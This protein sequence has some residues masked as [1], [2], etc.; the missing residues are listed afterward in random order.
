[1]GEAKKIQRVAKENGQTIKF[2]QA[3]KMARAKLKDSPEHKRN[4]RWGAFGG[5]LGGIVGIGSLGA[6]LN[7]VASR[8]AAML[9]RMVG[10]T[11]SQIHNYATA[12]KAYKNNPTQENE[13][14]LNGAKLG[15]GI[16]L[17]I[18]A[19]SSYLS[20]NNIPANA[21]SEIKDNIQERLSSLSESTIS[22][23]EDPFLPQSET[24]T[25]DSL[26][27]P[28]AT[29]TAN[30]V[31]DS[32]DLIGP[33]PQEM[34]PFEPV[35]QVSDTPKIGD[36]LS[37]K[38][39][40]NGIIETITLGKDGVPQQDVVGLSGSIE[41]SERIQAFYVRRI[42]NMNQ[43]NNLINMIGR[44]EHF[45]DANQAV[46]AMKKQIELGFVKLPDGLTPEHAI[47]T[48]FMH[49][50][51]TGDMSAIRA[52]ACPNGEETVGMFKEL[53]LKYSTD[54]GFIGRP[55]DPDIKL[56]MRA[57]TIDVKTPCEPVIYENDEIVVEQQPL[58]KT[59]IT[60][61]TIP[62]IQT[63]DEIGV[64][65]CAEPDATV[66]YP[67]AYAGHD[68]YPTNNDEGYSLIFEDRKG[69]GL[70]AKEVY[71]PEGVTSYR[72]K[73]DNHITLG[74]ECDE[75][76]T[77]YQTQRQFNI[78]DGYI[79]PEA[80]GVNGYAQLWG[81]KVGEAFACEVDGKD[82]IKYI[83]QEGTVVT[84]DPDNNYHATV[85]H[86]YLGRGVPQDVQESTV[87]QA[88]DSIN[89]QRADEIQ[90]NGYQKP[91]TTSELTRIATK[92]GDVYARLSTIVGRK[93]R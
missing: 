36:I 57:G 15:L 34:V 59:N 41:T 65:Y 90:V 11:S 47:H 51:Y 29:L 89:E 43:Y 78:R 12:N 70:T 67:A 75:N 60:V 84:F 55:V 58:E 31:A 32:T 66:E 72:L 8:G 79:V 2:A 3:W 17:T 1:L 14:K 49:G 25:L 44:G 76:I 35:A 27:S 77:A 28:S 71:A 86:M 30:D 19:V 39:Y 82:V 50:H 93:G 61:E 92:K 74:I 24:P 46:E 83:S 20:L 7:T 54:N 6:G 64:T 68:S 87:Q 88:I 13:A 80:E 73:G 37:Q 21:L 16:G 85:E 33:E 26:L 53:S 62:T 18:S 9:G 4:A 56:P 42:S 45:M 5:A 38:D 23:M 48:A 52:L 40:G 91:Q 69:D 81:G 63:I 10:S 22:V